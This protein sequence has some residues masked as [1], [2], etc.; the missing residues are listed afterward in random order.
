MLDRKKAAL[1]VIDLQ[2]SLFR[3]MDGKEDLLKNTGKLIAGARVLGLPLVLTEQ[4]KL[5]ETLSEIKAL[6]PGVEAIVKESFSCWR[7]E[8]FREHL[9]RLGRKELILAGIEAH[10]CVYQTAFDLMK[11]GYEVFIAADC[12]SSRIATNREIALRRLS[13]GGAHLVSAEM[14]LFELL[15]TAGDPLAKEIFRIVR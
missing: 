2:G 8:K 1:V 12:V 3:V 7:E 6:L 5:G 15:E 13:E 9:L 14:A 10:I 11:S 4:V